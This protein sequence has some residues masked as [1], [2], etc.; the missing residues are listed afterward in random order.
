MADDRQRVGVFQT[1]RQSGRRPDCYGRSRLL[2]RGYAQRRSVGVMRRTAA[3]WAGKATG[4]LSRISRLGGGTT[5]PG[6]VARAIDPDVLRKLSGDLEQGAIVITGTNGKTTTARL[7][8]WLLEGAGHSVVSNR[9]GANLIY[10]ATAA[11]LERAGANGKLKVDW[12]VYE[13]DE[14]S[15]ERA[16]DEIQPRA[17]IVLNLFRDQ[18]DRYGELET[19]AKKIESALARL[20]G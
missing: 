8:S 19:I 4:A 10:G 15:L 9:A 20:P 6:D 17:A 18:L 12:G 11:A 5:L 2:D 16:V 14:A 3:V 1:L 7:I 13:I